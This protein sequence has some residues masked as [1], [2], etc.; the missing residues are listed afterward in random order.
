[1]SLWV[2]AGIPGTQEAIDHDVYPNR[3]RT[4]DICEAAGLPDTL[5]KRINRNVEKSRPIEET[6]RS[7]H[8]L[9]QVGGCTSRKKLDSNTWFLDGSSVPI[10]VTRFS[11]P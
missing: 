7:K 10:L 11:P 8:K 3:K 5:V 6:P 2:M 4:Y 9:C 1:M